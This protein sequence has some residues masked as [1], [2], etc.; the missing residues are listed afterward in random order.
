MAKENI[1]TK[2]I[3]EVP[4]IAGISQL[5]TGQFDAQV[6]YEINEPILLE[7]EGFEVNLIKPRDYGINF[8]ADT[9]FT[10]EKMIKERPEAVRAFVQATIKGWESA[11]ANPTEAIDE[12]MLMNNT[13]DR[14]HQTKFF[15]LS[16]PLINAGGKIGYSDKNVWESIQEMLL[17]QEIMKNRVEIDKVFTND[18]LD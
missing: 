10:T 18:F 12:V 8:Y 5:T 14:E 3:E 11:L 2:K 15:E 17:N 16:V 7:Q 6:L 4:V 9:L 1:D 13:L